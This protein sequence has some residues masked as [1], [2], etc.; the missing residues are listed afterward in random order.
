MRN[1]LDMKKLTSH[2]KLV[3]SRLDPLSSDARS[4]IFNK[5]TWSD[6]KVRYLP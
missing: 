3:N 4:S 6:P 2:Q 5:L 1:G